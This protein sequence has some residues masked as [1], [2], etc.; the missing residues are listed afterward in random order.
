MILVGNNSEMI[1]IRELLSISVT[2]S[3]NYPTEFVFVF[4]EPP[5]GCSEKKNPYHHAVCSVLD[6]SVRLTELTQLRS[7]A[8]GH[9]IYKFG[10]SSFLIAYRY[11]LLCL[12]LAITFCGCHRI[13]IPYRL[14]IQNTCMQI[15]LDSLESCSPYPS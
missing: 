11:Y 15:D 9:I 6:T 4:R 8:V 7:V 13:F 12:C 1:R 10:R 3:G 2:M 14:Y 5:I